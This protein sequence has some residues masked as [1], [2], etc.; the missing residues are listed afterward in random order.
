MCTNKHENVEVINNTKTVAPLREFIREAIHVEFAVHQNLE[1]CIGTNIFAGS[2]RR[3]HMHAARRMC[4][5]CT[6]FFTRRAR[7]FL[8]FLLLDR[9]LSLARRGHLIQRHP[10]VHQVSVT[11]VLSRRRWIPRKFADHASTRMFAASHKA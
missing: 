5:G 11:N 8:F 1:A 2:Y 10:D 4:D 6:F 7:T 3:V 9:S